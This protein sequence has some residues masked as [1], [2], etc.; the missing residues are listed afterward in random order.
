MNSHG[1]TQ[2]DRLESEFG[3]YALWLAQVVNQ[4]HL[5]PIPVAC[6]GTG[7]PKL[8]ER[9]VRVLGLG[10]ES[11]LL[12]LGSGL[13]GPGQ[14]VRDHAGSEVVGAEIMESSVRGARLLFPGGRSVVADSGALPFGDGSFD[15]AWALGALETIEDKDETLSEV[16]RLLRPGARLAV[17]TFVPV[18]GEEIDAPTADRFEPRETLLARMERSELEL[19]DASEVTELAVSPGRWRRELGFVRAEVERRHAAEP[20]FQR[21]REQLAKMSALWRSRAITPWLFVLQK[22]GVRGNQ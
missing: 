6:R 14:W 19:V 13:G 21:C 2:R 15:A 17:Y 22:E 4:L 9:L 11:R 10:R 12:D 8:F 3:C 16:G 18:T 20:E 1:T 7:N 5:D